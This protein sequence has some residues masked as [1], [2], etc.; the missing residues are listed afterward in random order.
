MALSNQSELLALF[1]PRQ[2]NLKIPTNSGLL[3]AGIV[4][5]RK[6]T[7]DCWFYQTRS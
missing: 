3:Q 4:G 7:L 5:P 1:S 6:T 2:V